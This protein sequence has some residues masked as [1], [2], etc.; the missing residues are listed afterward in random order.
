VQQEENQQNFFIHRKPPVAQKTFFIP[1]EQFSVSEITWL[2]GYH[3]G[4]N[5]QFFSAQGGTALHCCFCYG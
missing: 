1:V 5:S 2:S 3:L 4:L